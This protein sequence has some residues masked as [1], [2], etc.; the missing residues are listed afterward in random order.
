MG[1]ET[2]R[3]KHNG[4]L[5]T[6]KGWAKEMPTGRESVLN[7]MRDQEL[8]RAKKIVEV[9]LKIL[10]AVREEYRRLMEECNDP[11]TEAAYDEVLDALQWNYLQSAV[12]LCR[13]ERSNRVGVLE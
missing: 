2:Q 4:I 7:E 6:K 3:A 9:N 12:W 10:K 1:T 11:K 13:L 5:A 8:K